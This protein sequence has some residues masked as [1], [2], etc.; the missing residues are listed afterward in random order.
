MRTN[1]LAVIFLGICPLLAAQQPQPVPETPAAPQAAPVTSSAAVQAKPNTLLDGTPVKMRIGRNISSA[2]AKVG[3]H[4][5]FEVLEEVQVMGVVVIAKGA[6]ASATV[7]EAQPKRRMG[8]EGKLEMTLDSVRLV[9]NEK[10][11]LTATAGGKGGSHT[12]AMV[13]AMVGT[14]IFTLGGSALFLLMHGKDITIPKGA[15]TTAYIRGDMALDMAKF[16][17]A[18]ATFAPIQ[19]P[20]ASPAAAQAS[21][22]I[23]SAPPGADIEIDGA[24]VGNTPSTVAVAAGSHQI[25]VK[26]KGFTD[27]TKT[28]NVTGGTVHLNAELEQGQAPEPTLA[29]I[30]PPPPPPPPATL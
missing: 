14:A 30:Q 26:K 24:F 10:A 19:A 23:D 9:D 12:G 25:V 28:L 15:E 18:P 3:E 4:V 6:T 13:G 22:A 17:V 1:S 29:P 21:L 27:W 11:A 20:A 5:D 7:T 2:D 16:G 8:R